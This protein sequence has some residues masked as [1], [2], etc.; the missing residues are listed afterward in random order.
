[1]P[2]TSKALWEEGAIFH[3]FILVRDGIFNEEELIRIMIEEPQQ[4]PGCSGTRCLRDNITDI[5]AQTA[6]NNTGIH[7]IRQL[8]EEYSMDV[9]QVS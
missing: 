2:P 8:I 9:V 4:Y 5:K 3:S 7:L 6:A 1:M